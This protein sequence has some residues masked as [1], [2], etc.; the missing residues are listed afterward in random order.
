[1][2]PPHCPFWQGIALAEPAQCVAALGLGK[3][4]RVVFD[5]V[6]ALCTENIEFHGQERYGSSESNLSAPLRP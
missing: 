3:D 6:S 1:M 2:L 5:F 4:V